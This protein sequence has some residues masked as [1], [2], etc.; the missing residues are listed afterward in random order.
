MSAP[1]DILKKIKRFYLFYGSNEYKLKERVKSM[2]KTV[3]TPGSEDFDLDHFDAKGTDIHTVINSLS[4]PPT[5][6]LLRV[7]IL[8]NTEKLSL[9]NQ[10]ILL[11]F[12]DKIPNYSMLAMVDVQPPYFGDC[13]LK[14]DIVFDHHPQVAPYQCSFR[15]VR[16][17]YGATSSI[18]TEYLL[19]ND[20]KINQRLATALLYGI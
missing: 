13:I 11:D 8:E 10:K 19:S 3:I 17:Q 2:I 7:V 15:D 14:T 4:T 9:N 18:L 20:I 1:E 6:S 16:E 5:M 12:F